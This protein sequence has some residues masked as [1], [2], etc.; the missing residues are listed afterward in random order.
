MK[1]VA[2]DVNDRRG[3]TLDGWEPSPVSRPPWPSGCWRC[4]PSSRTARASASTP[5]CSLRFGAAGALLLAVAA[6]TGRL[7]GLRPRVV[8][9]G[10]A[11]GAVGYAAQSGLYLAALGRVEASQAALLFCGYPLLVMVAPC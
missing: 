3:R 4:S 11:M 1:K 7:R 5:C 2:L 10:L 8:V 6:G 9:G